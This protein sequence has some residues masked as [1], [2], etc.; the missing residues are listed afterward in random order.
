MTVNW[1]S[2][3]VFEGLSASSSV[4]CRGATTF[5][6]SCSFRFFE[7]DT[8]NETVLAGKATVGFPG[9]CGVIPA[10][11]ALAKTWMAG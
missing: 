5:S 11:V 7:G 2:L 4:G 8:G 10:L 3:R 6:I 1:L 9:N